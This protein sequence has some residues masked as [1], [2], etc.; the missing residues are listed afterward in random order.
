MLLKKNL[1][2]LNPF[3]DKMCLRGEVIAEVYGSDG[4]LKQREVTHN[5]VTDQ[6]DDFAK[7]AIYTAAY[8]SLFVGDYSFGHFNGTGCGCVIG[9]VT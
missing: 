8:R 2:A 7:S 5:L 1:E 4:K 3:R 9:A 6:G